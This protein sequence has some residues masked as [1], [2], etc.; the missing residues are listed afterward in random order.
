M[1]EGAAGK[2]WD[3]ELAEKLGKLKELAKE[4]S[5][6]ETTRENFRDRSEALRRA[7]EALE[8]CKGLAGNLQASRSA[9]K[10]LMSL[11]QAGEAG[12]GTEGVRRAGDALLEAIGAEGRGRSLDDA[13]KALAREDSPAGIGWA[14]DRGANPE[15]QRWGWACAGEHFAPRALRELARRG[16][17]WGEAREWEEMRERKD[18]LTHPMLHMLHWGLTGQSEESVELGLEALR[19]GGLGHL[20]DAKYRKQLFRLAV[21]GSDRAFGMCG[22]LG[23]SPEDFGAAGRE[24]TIAGLWDELSRSLEG[25]RVGAWVESVREGAWSG[26]FGDYSPFG[27]GAETG[28]LSPAEALLEDAI[29]QLERGYASPGRALGRLSGANGEFGDIRGEMAK[30]SLER[31]TAILVGRRRPEEDGLD[32]RE[33]GAELLEWLGE[34]AAEK[35]VAAGR[36]KPRNM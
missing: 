23:I 19:E 28:S 14:L 15:C 12:W 6:T 26:S 29:R 32:I 36:R 18:P 7:G 13:L 24:E 25:K 34:V 5:E 20:P 30:E 2:S 31:V 4:L 3:E 21:A 33:P 10:A 16:A 35:G 22:D 1:A 11:C 9:W 8:E 17:L 27:G